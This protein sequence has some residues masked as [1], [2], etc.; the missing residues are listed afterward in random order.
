MGD[1]LT[2]EVNRALR[3]IAFVHVEEA[4]HGSH[5]GGLAGA[6]RAEERND[7]A[8][9]D[10]QGDSPEDQHDVVVHDLEVFDCQHRLS[11]SA[12]RG[13]DGPGGPSHLTHRWLSRRA[14]NRLR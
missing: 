13:W 7:L 4:G 6:V 2:V 14:C 8:V 5:R 1:I 10:L 12:V 11:D 3:D 9:A